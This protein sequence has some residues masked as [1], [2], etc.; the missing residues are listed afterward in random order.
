MD[1]VFLPATDPGDD[2]YGTIPKEL[3]G[4]PDASVR[5]V[6]YPTLVW[7]NDVVRREAIAQI[8]GWGVVSAVLVGFSKSGLGAWN[9]ARATPDIVSATIIFDAPVARQQLPPWETDAFYA[10]DTEWRTDLPANTIQSFTS[11]MPANHQLV[12]IAGAN[13][14][15][16]MSTLSQALD[17]AGLAHAFLRRPEM[18]HHWNS[19]WIEEGLNT[20]LE[21]NP[22]PCPESR[23][24]RQWK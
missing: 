2:A 1:L 4:Y 6:C 17:E 7:Y 12:L 18:T 8:R 11:A 5:Q 20:L 10:N 9:I 22:A 14:H 16:E 23:T 3:A 19:G 24:T 15:E 13:F 21:Q